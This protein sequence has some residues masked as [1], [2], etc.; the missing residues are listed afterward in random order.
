MTLVFCLTQ[1]ILRISFGCL[2]QIVAIAVRQLNLLAVQSSDDVLIRQEQA[3]FLV[4][5]KCQHVLGGLLLPKLFQVQHHDTGV[6]VGHIFRNAQP[7]AVHLVEQSTHVGAG[8]I[9][10]TVK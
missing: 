10:C 6:D 2:A 3:V 9:A 1:S 5:D 8:N 4:A 7:Q